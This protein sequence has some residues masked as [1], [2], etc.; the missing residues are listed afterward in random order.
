MA[1]GQELIAKQKRTE[2]SVRF[3]F[4]VFRSPFI[5]TTRLPERRTTFASRRVA[6]AKR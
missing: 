3:P 4:S 2:K 5:S 6:R 1:N